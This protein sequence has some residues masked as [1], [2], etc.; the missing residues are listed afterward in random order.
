MSSLDNTG[1]TSTTT[2]LPDRHTRCLF[3][4]HRSHDLEANVAHM[5]RAHGFQIPY[6]DRLLVDIETLLE[7]L[8]TTINEYA[9][10][11]HCFTQRSTGE[12]A[13]QHMLGK[14][15]CVIDLERVE[16][17]YLDFYD[18]GSAEGSEDEDGSEAA[19]SGDEAGASSVR[20]EDGSVRLQSGKI[21]SHRK[22]THPR[23]THHRGHDRGATSISSS[24]EETAPSSPEQDG[25][26]SPRPPNPTQL[27]HSRTTAPSTPPPPSRHDLALAHMRSSDRTALAHLPA[28][29]QR[30]LLA[31]QR[32]QANEGVRAQQAMQ[33]SVEGKGN[34]TLMKY[35]KPRVP[36]RKNGLH[37]ASLKA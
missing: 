7:Y 11:I 31:T 15:H 36:K 26:S 34:K 25:Q 32:K 24:L 23:S 27:T 5:F 16:S 13:R 3:C 1:D 28:A 2:M 33:A 12:A 20:L 4:H 19:G 8:D 21:V 18:F 30:A 37:R 10:C 17:E 6:Q 22:A 9:Q 14:A 35:F 29:Q